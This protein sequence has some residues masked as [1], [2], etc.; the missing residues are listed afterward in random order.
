MIKVYAIHDTAAEY[1]M[2]PFTAPNDNVAKRLF[3]SSMGD[4]FVHRADFKLFSVGEFDSDTG[5][6]NAWDPKLV[7][8]GLSIDIKLDPRV[9]KEQS[10]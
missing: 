6:L 1:F 7:L 3:V 8:A 10:A 9:N 4:S 5:G 2:P